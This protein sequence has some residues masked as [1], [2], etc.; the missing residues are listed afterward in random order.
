MAMYCFSASRHRICCQKQA[1]TNNMMIDDIT[2]NNGE[3]VFT[4]IT[5]RFL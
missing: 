2:N 3:K 4:I 5:N 1:S